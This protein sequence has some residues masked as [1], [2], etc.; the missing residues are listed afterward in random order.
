V[1]SPVGKGSQCTG[2]RTWPPSSAVWKLWEPKTLEALRAH[3]G[4][5]RDSLALLRK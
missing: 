5:Y 1:I 3:P 2:L 4:L